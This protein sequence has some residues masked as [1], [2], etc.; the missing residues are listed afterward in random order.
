MLTHL[1]E[2]EG[3]YVIAAENAEVGLALTQTQAF[4]LLIID[5][6][7]GREDGIRLCRRVR[8]FDRYTPV[9]IYSGAIHE[10]VQRNACLA[11]A[12]AFVPKPEVDELIER[13]KYFLD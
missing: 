4:D 2:R 6:W 5:V 8:E 11:E 13:V 9:I 1:L 10:A 7:L 12:D 3:Y